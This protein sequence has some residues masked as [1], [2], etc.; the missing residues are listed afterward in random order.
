MSADMKPSSRENIQET[1][2]VGRPPRQG[3]RGGTE[4]GGLNPHVSGS[5]GSVD[6]RLIDCR[7][8]AGFPPGNQHVWFTIV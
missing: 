4:G 5:Q 8:F 2:C 6:N 7:D 3:W 1:F